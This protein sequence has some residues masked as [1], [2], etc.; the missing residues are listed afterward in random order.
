MLRPRLIL[1]SASPRR[2]ELLAQLGVPFE[3]ITAE[4]TEHE[5]PSTDPRVMVAH[6]AA[7]KAAWVAARHPEAFVLGADTTVF[8]DGVALN[9][10]CDLAE[11]RAMLRRLSGRTHTVFTGVAV[12]RAA[13]RLAVDEGVASEVTFKAL[14][15][16]VIEEYLAAV[17][18]LD[19]AGGYAIQ[20]RGDLIVAGF[21]GSRTNIVGLPLET[22][23][24]ILTRCGLLA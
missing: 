4:V 1:A 21:R 19:K 9:K 14:S 23:K 18:T 16:E 11:A 5:E 7:L 3:V 22:T 15:P 10:P 20:E 8:L 24:Q 17:H 2:R 13:G 6:N 12:R